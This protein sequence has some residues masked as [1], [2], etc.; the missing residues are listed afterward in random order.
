MT[1]YTFKTRDE[2]RRIAPKLLKFQR[3]QNVRAK[4]TDKDF[5]DEEKRL[6]EEVSA[7]LEAIL[8][9]KSDAPP[10]DLTE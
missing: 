2:S 9:A 10:T 7:M 6:D 4:W 8:N 3:A 5:A 1:E